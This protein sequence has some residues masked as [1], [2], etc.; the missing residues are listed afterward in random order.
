MK[1][2]KIFLIVSTCLLFVGCGD[3]SVTRS[4]DLNQI[5]IDNVE[6]LPEDQKDTE[7][8]KV[9][10]DMRTYRKDNVKFENGSVTTFAMNDSQITGQTK[11]RPDFSNEPT[12]SSYARIQVMYDYVQNTVG[13]QQREG[14]GWDIAQCIDPRMNAIYDDQDKGVAE[15]YEN[16]NIYVAEYETKVDNVY[17]YFIMVREDKNS[18]WKVIYDGIDYKE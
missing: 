1:R 4:E 17:S 9:L 12:E 6:R 3:S 13:V 18:E 15:S 5:S 14:Y 16:E 2:L 11:N 10:T 7:L 8:N